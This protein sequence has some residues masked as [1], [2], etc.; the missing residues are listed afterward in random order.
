LK[1]LAAEF[2]VMKEKG[3]DDLYEKTIRGYL[4]RFCSLEHFMSKDAWL[5]GY[6]FPEKRGQIWT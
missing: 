6:S 4:D 1:Q 5:K 2:V 3:L